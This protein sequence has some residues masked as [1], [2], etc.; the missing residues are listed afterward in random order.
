M[1]QLIIG[2]EGNELLDRDSPMGS[3]LLIYLQKI[4]K[5]QNSKKQIFIN[6]RQKC[7]ENSK[8]PTEIEKKKLRDR[9]TER[10]P[11]LYEKIMHR[12]RESEKFIVR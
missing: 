9:E 2:Q 4:F 7:K 11:F 3:E 1:N 5:K 12:M 10:E 8:N 6:L